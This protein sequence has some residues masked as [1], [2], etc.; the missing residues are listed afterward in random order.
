MAIGN[1]W[2]SNVAN[3]SATKSGT[4]TITLQWTNVSGGGTSYRV[5]IWYNV[6]GGGTWNL[7]GYTS[8]STSSKTRTFDV[9]Y[10]YGFRTAT[11]YWCTEG[12]PDIWEWSDHSTGGSEPANP[13]AYPSSFTTPVYRSIYADTLT[14][15]LT[16]SGSYTDAVTGAGTYSYDAEL[17]TLTLSGSYTD[18]GTFYDTLTGTLTLSGSYVDAVIGTTDYGYYWGSEGGTIHRYLNTTYGDAGNAITSSWTSKVFDFSDMSAELANCRKTVYSVR[19]YYFD[20]ASSVHT[21]IKVSTD[22]GATWT[23][24]TKSIGTGNNREK[25]Q[26][27][28][29]ILDG[30]N[31]QFKIEHSSADKTFQWTGMR[32][33][34]EPGGDSMD[35]N[36]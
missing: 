29:F 3:I 33:E 34:F 11:V 19:L 7:W 14:G 4:N 17:S 10:K 30:D 28:D 26:D 1:C 15:T 12:T 21:T 9:G 5:Y 6:D 32:V 31:F 23:S 25:T 24:R 20:S 18:V 36:D 35:L 16:L 8:G 27:F 2:P 13:N 22:G